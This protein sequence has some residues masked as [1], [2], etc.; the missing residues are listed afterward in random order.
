MSDLH[1]KRKM[2][3]QSQTLRERCSETAPI[4]KNQPSVLLFIVYLVVTALLGVF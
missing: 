4:L 1:V 3:L 2:E